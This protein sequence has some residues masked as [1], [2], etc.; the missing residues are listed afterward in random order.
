M[1]IVSVFLF[2]GGKMIH[3]REYEFSDDWELG[4]AVDKVEGDYS[5]LF[6]DD[7]IIVVKRDPYS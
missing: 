7:F 2:Q 1:I 3:D 6:R 5:S 4:D